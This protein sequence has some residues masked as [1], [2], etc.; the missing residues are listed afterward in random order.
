MWWKRFVYLLS[1]SLVA[2]LNYLLTLQ[3]L[4]FRQDEEA[5]LFLDDGNNLHYG[6]FNDPHMNGQDDPA[7]V[8]R[9][10]EALQRVVARTSK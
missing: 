5:P 9:E 6:S 4:S 1:L 3:C 7:E 10:V 2:K 8:Q